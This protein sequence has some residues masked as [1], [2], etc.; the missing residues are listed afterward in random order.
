MHAKTVPMDTFKWI[1]TGLLSALVFGVGWFLSGIQADLRDMRREVAGI[2]VD[3]A[4]V[5]TRLESIISEVRRRDS[6]R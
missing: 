2:R 1:V 4:V 6:V 3:A 5:T